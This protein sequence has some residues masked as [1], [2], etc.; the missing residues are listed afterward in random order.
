MLPCSVTARLPVCQVVWLVACRPNNSS[1]ERLCERLCNKSVGMVYWLLLLLHFLNKQLFSSTTA[2]HTRSRRSSRRLD[3]LA[4]SKCVA[5]MRYINLSPADRQTSMENVPK[6]PPPGFQ[7]YSLWEYTLPFPTKPP[8][9]LSDL[10]PDTTDPTAHP[11][12]HTQWRG[13]DKSLKLMRVQCQITHNHR[14]S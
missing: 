5:R 7:P 12:Q 4:N 8:V 13:I 10:P 6:S 14:A 3:N 2:E 9:F 1:R 11:Q